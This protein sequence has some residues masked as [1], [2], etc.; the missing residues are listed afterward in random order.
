M[1]AR[2]ALPHFGTVALDSLPAN[3][4]DAAFASWPFRFWVVHDGLVALKPMPVGASYDIGEL[5]RY[6]AAHFGG[7]EAAAAPA[8]AGGTPVAAE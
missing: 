3:A 7:D 8:A 5:G 6:L 1:L 2:L 4:F